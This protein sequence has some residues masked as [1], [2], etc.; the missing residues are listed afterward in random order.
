L[1][2]APTKGLNMEFIKKSLPNSLTNDKLSPYINNN[3]PAFATLIIKNDKTVFKGVQGCAVLKDGKCINKAELNT[4]FSICSVTKHF[5]AASI[6]MLEEEGKLSIDDYITKYIPNLPPRFKGIKIKHLIFQIS[7][8][9]DYFDDP[10]ARDFNQ[11]IKQGKKLTEKKVF[12]FILKSKPKPYSKEYNYSN[13]GYV[14]L[15]KIIKN[16]S[17]KTYAQ[18]IQ[19]RFFDA[20]G[21]KDAFVMSSINQ[22]SNYT[23][24][25]SQW[26]LYQPTHWMKATIPSGEGGIFLSINDFE[27]WVYAFSQ[28]KI[29]A[30]K[31]TMKKFLSVGKYD[32]GKAVRFMRDA[33]KYGF[34]LIHS[35]ENRNGKK[36]HVIGHDGGMPGTLAVFANIRNDKENIWVVYLNNAGSYPDKFDVL[37]QAKVS[38]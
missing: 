14:L 2:G 22:H 5:T 18:F 17:G 20:F 1:A 7:G 4:P 19:Q 16:T 26:P 28:N 34:G 3:T 10:S 9:P 38:Y 11:M 27:K 6:L 15:A 31:Q 12:E 33:N 24:A 37:E 32:N 36:Y 25:Y 8:I 13:S 29:F 21:M 23:E 30:K 35:E